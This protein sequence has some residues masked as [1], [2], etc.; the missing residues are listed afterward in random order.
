MPNRG[1]FHVLEGNNTI[2]II[3]L[4]HKEKLKCVQ[5]Y[6]TESYLAEPVYVLSD[7]NY[8]VNIKVKAGKVVM[9]YDNIDND[10]GGKYLHRRTEILLT[11]YI[12]PFC[13]KE[14]YKY[15]E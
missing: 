2:K 7:G 3:E 14:K 9:N 10:G 6:N 12:E 15:Y 5:V 4:I 13:E 8:R 11:V 1:D